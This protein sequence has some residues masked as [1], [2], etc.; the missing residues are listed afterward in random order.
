MGV[1]ALNGCICVIVYIYTYVCMHT[2]TYIHTY[3]HKDRQA[4]RQTWV[5]MNRIRVDK[6]LP[7]KCMKPVK[8]THTR[9][10]AH[11]QCVHARMSA[12][13]HEEY[14]CID[15]IALPNV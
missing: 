15:V 6:C 13:S 7:Q 12:R 8:Y 3:I 11:T 4:H 9:K 5:H 2:Y 14:L 10:H 1:V